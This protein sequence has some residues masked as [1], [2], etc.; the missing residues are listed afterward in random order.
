MGHYKLRKKRAIFIVF[1]LIV[2][3]FSIKDSNLNFILNASAYNIYEDNNVDAD[4][5]ID[6]TAN[7]GT[8]AT[9]YLDAQILDATDQ[10]ITEGNGAGYVAGVNDENDIDNDASDI[11]ASADIGTQGTFSNAQG[12]VA[13]TTYMNI[14][15]GNGPGYVAA[16]T[17]NEIHD[18]IT[19]LHTP[20]DIGT[21][22]NDANM[23]SDDGTMNT[24]TEVDGGGAG[25]PT[26]SNVY[27]IGTGK[28]ASTTDLTNVAVAGSNTGLLCLL[29]HGQKTNGG[30]AYATSVV[31]DVAGV[32]EALTVVTGGQQQNVKSVVEMWLKVAPTSK[33]ATVTVT[34][35]STSDTWNGGTVGCY[36]LNNLDQSTPYDSP[37]DFRTGSGTAVSVT[38]LTATGDLTIDLAQSGNA[39]TYTE[40]GDGT[41]E[42]NNVNTWSTAS[43]SYVATDG[44]SDHA[45]TA[46]LSGG[47]SEVGISLNGIGGVNYEFD[48]EFSFT[49]LPTGRTTER[50]DINTGTIGTES[51]IVQIWEASAWTTVVTI[52]D[53]NDGVW[54]NTSISSWM[55]AT[56]ED[57][58]FLGGT[59]TT[60]TTLNT[61]EIDMVMILAA[62]PE[63]LDYELDFEY[64]WTTADAGQTS[65]EVSIWVGPRS[66]AE[67][68]VVD[69]WSGSW[70]NIGT[71]NAASTHFNFTATGIASTYT[72]RFT[73]S[74]E[75]ADGTQTNWDI[76]LITLHT[77]TA[78]VLDYELQWEHQSTTVDTNKDTYNVTIYGSA[79]EDME[80]QT[81]DIGGTA[82][83]A[84]LT[85]QISTTEQWYNQTVD[86]NA[87]GT[88]I[89]W[90]Y[91][92]TSEA[93]DAVQDTFN[94]D[95]AGVAAWNHT[96]DI[97]EASIGITDYK[98]GS[99]N[100]SIDEGFMRINVTSGVS[101]TI[102]IRGVDGTR[103]P[104]TSNW[105]FFD[106]DSDPAGAI[107]LTTSYQNVYI[108]NPAADI[109][110]SSIYIF[111]DI[112]DGEDDGAVTAT[113]WVQ[114]I[115]A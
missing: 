54:I 96:M 103:S 115:V 101:Y 53:A 70:T 108:G 8:D 73:G 31:W 56:T 66:D 62:S 21:Y 72:L 13:D 58:R 10:I 79:T 92:G 55:D 6:A 25:T 43:S 32:G 48:R 22:S 27:F 3:P 15:E 93:A 90:R 104:V 49:G 52:V 29:G 68:I 87:I 84:P 97:I 50:L 64:Q 109:T 107:Q 45:W 82:W 89:T 80:I 106:I 11:D 24:L 9:S 57:F 61:W 35:T 30:G 85:L 16:V 19:D 112:P 47:W 26:I 71:I 18:A 77:W 95:Y 41:E 44:S 99:G 78:E 86:A 42:Y 1:M 65:E 23:Q 5:D 40:S 12:T 46:S 100:I 88:T 59:E 74:S 60:D 69:Y 20:T 114:I 91:R 37:V 110:V 67:N 34:W 39:A 75:A 94:I 33:T 51:L 83:N 17:S 102:Q 111:L 113:I 4:S 98:Q 105:L 76:D 28:K 2:L 36:V 14:Q 38:I 7:I 81:W 63:S